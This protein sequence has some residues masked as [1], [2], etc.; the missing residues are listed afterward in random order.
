M[1]ARN[2]L[3]LAL[4]AIAIILGL[5][6]Y[7]KPGLEPE[8]A[9]QRLTTLLD[10]EE[11]IGIH[12][13]RITRDPLS[14]IKR[15]GHWYLTA[16]ERELP[17]SDF[18]LQDLLHLLE[19]TSTRRYA[20]ESVDLKAIGLEPPQATVTI[21]DVK[22]LFGNTETL[23]NNRYALVDKTVHLIDDRYQH[24]VNA[25]WTNF[26]ERKLVPADKIIRTLQLPEMTLTFTD[27]NQWQLSP[28][29]PDVS[30][31]A[32]QQLADH[33]KN[34]SALYARRYDGSA[35][36]ETITL[37]LSDMPEPLTFKV[38]AHSPEL[39]LARPDWGIQ[40]HFSGEMEENLLSLQETPA[41]H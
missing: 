6:V 7:F 38:I 11:A 25:D 39:I 15:D 29:R 28:A 22:F 14:F 16:G 5:L 30:A 21:N 40:Y 33:W 2:L 20:A 13:E 18:Q 1:A 36:D 23:E 10:P 31:D 41:E 8:P 9:P 24:L 34:A 4:V 3:N 32:V 27:R 35:S 37:E 12:I 26:V 19:T 17:A